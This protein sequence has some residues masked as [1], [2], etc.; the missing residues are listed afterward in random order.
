MAEKPILFSGEMVRAI[1]EGRKTQTRRVVKPQFNHKWGSGVPHGYDKFGVHVDIPLIEP[2]PMF[3]GWA[4]LFCPYG[5]A[6]D[7][8][9]VRE[10]WTDLT[11]LFTEKEAFLKYRADAIGCE[12]SYSWRPSIFMPRWASRITLE[13]ERI[14]V[15]R[16]QD[17][18]DSSCE[19]EGVSL[20]NA[21]IPG[22]L[23]KRFQILWDSINAKRGFPWSSN[24]WVWVISFRL[25]APQPRLAPDPA[26]CANQA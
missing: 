23:R 11:D 13:I 1:L 22:Y 26:S 24:P 14:S 12:D 2:H 7:H 18:G 6:G 3:G 19:A 10:T 25:A 5:K 20:A 9:W 8:L 15:E 4:Y 17:I 16:V 21:S